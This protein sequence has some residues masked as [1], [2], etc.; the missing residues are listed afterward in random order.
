MRNVLASLVFVILCFQ[1]LSAQTTFSDPVL[2][3]VGNTPVRVSEFAYIYS[4]T[5]QNK[6]DFSEASL[7]EYMDL[8]IK[9]KMKVQKAR[10]MKYDTIPSLKAELEGYRRQV[11]N[12]Y[13]IDKEVTDRL[14][15]DAHARMDR[16]LELSHIVVNCKREAP[17]ADTL[18]AYNKALEAY[19]KVKGGMKFEEA[20]MQYSD[21]SGKAENKG[22]I[23]W[24]TAFL[25]AGFY[26]ME[27][28]VYNAKKG[29]VLMP[30]RSDFG[31]HVVRV[32]DVRPARGEM[33]IAHILVRNGE[34]PAAA[35][36]RIE[37]VSAKLMTGA[38]WDETCNAYSDDKQ[39]ST[40]G[41]YL[42]FFGINRYQRTFEEAAFSIASNGAYSAPVE[43]AVGWHIIKRISTKK[44]G[45][46]EAEKR[47][48]TDLVKRDARSEVARQNMITNI[49]KVS[50]FK[51]N[52]AALDKWAAMQT[53][54][55]L[56]FRW[57]PTETLDQTVL[58]NY[59]KKDATIADFEDFCNRTSRERMSGAGS[60]PVREMID[61]LYRMFTDDLAMRYEESQ[62]E[63]KYPDFKSLMREYEEGNLLFFAAK[64]LVWDKANVDSV[65]LKAFFDRE[66]QGKYNWEE[67][68]ALSYYTVMSS[69]SI[70]IGK[71]RKMA[72]TKPTAAVLKKFNKKTEVVKIAE[73]SMEKS[74]ITDAA[75]AGNAPGY[76]SAPM[77][78]GGKTANFY[79][80]E[81]MI[82]P[83]PKS[84]SE[85]KGY[86]VA[87]YQDFL[88]KEWITALKKEY[89]VKVE[90]DIFKM[91]VKQ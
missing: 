66:L 9:F 13:L 67:R 82:P 74:K 79:K 91:L 32:G 27:V 42:G 80:I 38:N 15:R 44:V 3:M 76:V 63:T 75:I 72:A 10:D 33:E 58:C 4:K 78:E 71:V 50:N 31:Y 77:V 18:A 86:A 89:P 68:K 43:T 73:K 20:V 53:D 30:I 87:D 39:T 45:A 85:C 81:R 62:L 25:P 14:V 24:V 60:V 84:L 65:G 56:T 35:K 61:R 22:T 6:A 28:E 47:R 64:E 34:N 57:K 59:G 41:G 40:K 48:L 17:A 1:S 26:Q 70:L 49:K 12:S 8:Y 29:D 7:R 37:E 51:E 52:P 55:F 23:G 11:A 21:D 90:E 69:D 88:E 5:N 46:Y 36:T 2:F 16:D 19:N 83:G 54:T